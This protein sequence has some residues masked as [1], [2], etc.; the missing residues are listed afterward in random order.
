[1]L[2]ILKE[3]KVKA[4]LAKI[5]FWNIVAGAVLITVLA[6]GTG[7]VTFTGSAAA[8][9]K[10]QSSAAVAAALT[11]VCVAAAN[12]DP[13]RVERLAELSAASAFSRSGKVEGYGWANAPGT[14]KA[15]K[16]VAKECAI[17]VLAV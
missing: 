5:S 4:L 6:F 2:V 9:A 1:M 7:T 17:A 11:P 15:N 13:L 14:D 3:G 10:A 8:A 16:D 12:A